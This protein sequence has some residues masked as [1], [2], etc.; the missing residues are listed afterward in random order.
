MVYNV[1]VWNYYAASP[2]HNNNL[3]LRC[4]NNQTAEA[5]INPHPRNLFTPHRIIPSVICYS[6][7]LNLTTGGNAAAS[8]RN[9]EHTHDAMKFMIDA[10]LIHFINQPS[11]RRR[12]FQVHNRVLVRLTKCVKRRLLT[13]HHIC[14]LLSNRKKT[15]NYWVWLVACC[16]IS[17]RMWSNEFVT[18]AC[19]KCFEWAS[20]SHQIKITWNYIQS[21]AS[22]P[23][24]P[25]V[26]VLD[27]QQHLRPVNLLSALLH[28]Y[29]HKQDNGSRW[30]QVVLLIGW[31]FSLLHLMRRYILSAHI[32]IAK[33]R[34]AWDSCG[35]KRSR[36]F[37]GRRRG[38][39]RR[40]RRCDMLN[41]P[42]AFC[43]VVVCIFAVLLAAFSWAI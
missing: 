27:G 28:T 18:L 31:M 8:Q 1:F 15:S 42:I 24:I 43:L 10:A 41:D 2:S 13:C 19:I 6:F 4:D 22:S 5:A 33:M 36:W 11:R 23:A 29:T 9:H 32:Y 20:N 26:V 12:P 14:R 35:T 39:R 34:N 25:A 16:H 30:E 21:R 17:S 40:R 3:V 7:I 38:V 37:A